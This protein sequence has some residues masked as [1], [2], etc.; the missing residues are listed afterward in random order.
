MQQ[1]SLMKNQNS[2]FKIRKLE[3]SDI[4]PDSGFFYCLRQLSASKNIDMDKAKDLF[5]EL[6]K[7]NTNHA[8]V[9]IIDSGFAPIIGT[10]ILRIEK[11]FIHN[12]SQ[13]GLIDMVC[14]REEFKGMGVGSLLIDHLVNIAKKEEC[15]KISLICVKKLIPFY[16]KNGFYKNDDEMRLD[17]YS[18]T[19]SKQ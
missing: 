17:V 19:G 18:A 8:Y 1:G 2:I 7:D 14:V 3:L 9:A 4:T 12:C 11:Q 16:E 6:D 15:Y 5:G 10:A 13:Y